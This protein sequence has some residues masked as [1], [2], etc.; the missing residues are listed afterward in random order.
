MTKRNWIIVSLVLVCTLTLGAWAYGMFSPNPQVAAIQ[1]LR[2][3]LDSPDAKKMPREERHKLRAELRKKFEELPE[4]QRREMM[5]KG[6]GDFQAH[7]QKRMDELF[8]L[9]PEKRTAAIDKMIDEGESR[10]RKRSERGANKTAGNRGQGGGPGGWGRRG[11]GGPQ[12]ENARNE[13]R[14]RMMANTTP[15]QRAQFQEFRR[16]VENRRRERGLPENP[17]WH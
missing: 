6:H 5:S 3:K 7:M 17:R 8:T 2:S 15:K 9:P 14:K 13:R 12:S 16:L 4:D 1:E 10:Q 11:G